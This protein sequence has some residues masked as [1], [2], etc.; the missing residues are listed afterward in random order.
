[1]LSLVL[2]LTCLS[3]FGM[4]VSAKYPKYLSEHSF[5]I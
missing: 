3:L 1:L 4:A 5:N 2:L